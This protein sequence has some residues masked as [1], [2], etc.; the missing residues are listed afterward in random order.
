MAN[1]LDQIVGGLSLERDPEFKPTAPTVEDAH[2]SVV[3]QQRNTLKANM[4]VAGQRE[5]DR[6]AKVIE[7]ANR[8]KLPT[9]FVERNYDKL[10]QKDAEKSNDFDSLVAQNPGLAKFLENPD[11]AT[12]A[13]DDIDNLKKVEN[14]VKDYGFG[15]S[16][17][18]SLASG[19][20]KAGADL[21][22][23][24]SFLLDAWLRRA[25]FGLVSSQDI[26]IENAPAQYLERKQKEFHSPDLDTNI[27]KEIGAGNYS[28]AGKGLAAQ[29]VSSSPSMVV[30]LLSTAYG[31]P[32]A[33]LGLI[34]LQSASGKYQENIAGGGPTPEAPDAITGGDR[35]KDIFNAAAT[36]GIEVAA[37]RMGTFGI[38]KNWDNAIA[39]QYGKAVSREV[40]L[41]F[42]K[43]ILHSAAT[44]A[45][46]EA[47]TS[48]A[49]DFT[50]YFTGENEDALKGIGERAVNAGLVGAVAGG[51][52]TSLSGAAYG[53]S[54]A[55]AIKRTE[56]AKKFYTALGETAEETKL[57]DRLPEGLKEAVKEIVADTPVKDIYVSPEAIETFFQGK[58]EN[59]VAIMQELGV[60]EEFKQA[61]ESGSDVKIPL[62]TW[63]SKFVG[64]DY[65]QGL[66]NDI[67]FS[68]S[69]LSVNEAKKVK[70]RTEREAKE[71]EEA[72]PREQEKADIESQ[73]SDMLRNSA[74]FDESTARSYSKLYG[75]AF[76]ALAERAGVNA[77]E[78]LGRYG[79]SVNREGFVP[80]Q[81][82]GEADTSFDFG[83]NV[84]KLPEVELTPE[85]EAEWAAVS[86]ESRKELMQMA[87][88][89]LA[90]I[91]D[92]STDAVADALGLSKL[93]VRPLAKGQKRSGKKATG[94]YSREEI[95]AAAKDGK[96]FEQT[97][98]SGTRGK[99]DLRIRDN[100][101]ISLTKDADLSTFL[102]ETGHF[103]LEVMGDLAEGEAR[104]IEGTGGTNELV[105]DY[106]SIL[107]FLGADSREGIKRV[108]HEK[109]ARAF[110]AYLMEGKA[111]SADLRPAFSRFRAWLISIYKQI[112]ALAVD[113]N[114]EIREVFDRM[115][116]TK[117]EIEAARQEQAQTGWVKAMEKAGFKGEELESMRLVE[118]EAAL[119]AE[120]QLASK[121]MDETKREATKQW[122]EERA[123]VR[124]EVEK[125]VNARPAYVALS[126]LGKGTMPDGSEIPASATGGF[127][128]GNLAPI[129]LSKEVI[130]NTWG[131][132]RLESLPRPYV[133]GAKGGVHPE[134]AAEMFG[135]TSGDQLLFEIT[136]AEPREARIE[137]ETDEAMKARHGD[138]LT[139]GTL[140]EEAVR[141]VHND[142]QAQF[143]HKKL[144]FLMKNRQAA[145]KEGVRRVSKRLPSVKAVREQAEAIIAAKAVREIRPIVYQ[146]AESRAANEAKEAFLKGDF[147]L[148]FDWQQKELLA[149]E[150]YRAAVAANEGVEKIVSY[151]SRFTKD[152]KR[153]KMGKASQ[154]YLEQIDGI[155]ERFNLKSRSL[156]S[157][158]KSKS[159][160]KWFEEQK[161]EG[162]TPDIPEYLLHEAY[163]KHYKDAS[164]E[165]LLGIRDSIKQIEHLANLKNK[166]LKDAKN[167]E[168]D[169]AVTD[170][171]ASIEANAKN[172]R[173]KDLEPR[174][175]G[176]ELYRL[177]AG[178]LA[179]HRK[180]ASLLRAMDGYKDGGPMWELLTRP[181]NVAGDKEAVLLERSTKEMA[182]IF[183]VYSKL[184]MAKMQLTKE[185]IPEL[186]A[187]LTKAG[188]IMVALNVGNA[189]NRRKLMEGR[190]WTEAQLNAVL[191]RLDERDWKAVQAVWDHIDSY[192]AESKAITERVHGMAPE[193]VEAVPVKTNFG[194]YKGGYFPLKYESREAPRAHAHLAKEAAERA[195]RGGAI[196][197]TTKSAHRTESRVENVKMPVRLDLGVIFE[198]ITEVIHDQTHYEILIDAN[199]ILGDKRIQ[200]AILEHYGDVVYDQMRDAVNDIAAGSIP[201]QTTV[202][203]AFNRIRVGATVTG[204][205]FNLSTAMLQPLGLTQS[206]VRV[207]PKWV[208]K[209]IGRWLGDAARMQNTTKWIYERSDFMRLRS[210]TQLREVNEIR[211]AMTLRGAT[212]GALDGSYFYMIAKMQMVA[213][214]PTWVGA[215]EKAM[216]ENGQ[217]E[218]R[219]VAI[220]DQAVIDA[221]GSGQM[222]DLAQ[223]QRGGPLMKLFTNFYSFFSTT[224]NLAAES[225]GRTNFRNPYDV[226]L[227]AVDYMLLFVVPAT[228]SMMVKSALRGEDEEEL[229]PDGG[230]SEVASYAMG[231]MIGLRELGSAVQGFDYAGPAGARFF[232]EATKLYNQVA[233]GDLDAAFWRSLNNSAG[234]LLH[235]PAGQVQ[236]TFEGINAYLDGDA[237]PTAAITG[238]PRK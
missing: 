72:A 177:G 11:N 90:N 55:R 80:K 50:D 57:K 123:R 95:L 130:V 6:H 45:K 155:L 28:K 140:H 136:N 153:A 58:N 54:R 158:D 51:G 81:K 65:Y 48:I 102:H 237:P 214:I 227:L 226:G 181:F 208:A 52:P 133:Y 238:K 104:K 125:R 232:A 98:E 31:N 132:E 108:H 236:K 150:L 119:A 85:E 193:K 43:T 76:T 162:F 157:V 161:A 127:G 29:A 61:K 15:D 151:L 27:L 163:K 2:A 62:Q 141:S 23:A 164:Y 86:Q 41:D 233:E 109:F 120:E 42:T 103:Y 156:K 26:P 189:D 147:D 148:A 222:K 159:L 3:E 183:G 12:V 101:R 170:A 137:R 209:G 94:A 213:D 235:Y 77:S 128:P 139:D 66:Q 53:V 126:V 22:R 215:Y 168:I 24:P 160:L 111:P 117:E 7:L 68:E 124:A 210:K 217:D 216:A 207:G 8:A 178:F 195:L 107:K 134:T 14:S 113:L 10:A 75:A 9:S 83:E 36:G 46:E 145:V 106:K 131:K 225:A 166:L 188:Q 173:K 219:A 93:A 99:I 105:E 89:A 187:S 176:K 78:L 35:G 190:G 129:K 143:L 182:N 20:S 5:P 149:H 223:V 19:L 74:G 231:T 175:P 196:R 171:T 34:G 38:L 185:Y 91:P 186:G 47:I 73:V 18:D 70:E 211:N 121:I 25:A 69:D 230:V 39:K 116:A 192:W 92:V 221:Q 146:R 197:S 174:L 212:I 88:F 234:I 152:D 154:S 180:M 206:M 30:A 142:K 194:T 4:F 165:E 203:K 110:E 122:K 49:Q 37:E 32:S 16:L 100:I 191:D 87:R 82:A 96:G 1:E 114:P 56:D 13:R 17:M 224:F 179:S 201:A 63:V 40:M 97:F 71:A 112:R 84:Q 167:R 184:E 202:D 60:S 67:K 64:T 33:G 79:L 144:E 228:L 200:K 138:M 118:Q 172:V 218:D 204:L 205:G 44:E 199:R 229:F 220:A 115:L 21:A 135:Y 169:E 198:H 59:P